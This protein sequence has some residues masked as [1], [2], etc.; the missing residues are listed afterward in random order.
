MKRKL[1]Q[2]EEEEENKSIKKE[3]L[4]LS[5]PQQTWFA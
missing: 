5:A 1:R 4:L 2:R 3:G